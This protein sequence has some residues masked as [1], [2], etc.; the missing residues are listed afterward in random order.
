[1]RSGT[2]ADRIF[3]NGQRWIAHELIGAVREPAQEALESRYC[4]SNRQPAGTVWSRA[5][6][7]TIGYP[8]EGGVPWQD[9]VAAAPPQ[10]KIMV[11]GPGRYRLGGC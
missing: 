11:V 6:S 7:F 3:K 4:P 8:A 9:V 2:V 1:M 5:A 10:V